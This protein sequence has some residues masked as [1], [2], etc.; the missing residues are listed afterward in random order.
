MVSERET[1]AAG[2]RVGESPCEQDPTVMTEGKELKNVSES[3]SPHESSEAATIQTSGSMF[4]VKVQMPGSDVLDIQVS[5]K[6]LVQEIIQVLMEH[7]DS[8]HRTCFSLQ[9]EGNVLDN[10][11][12]LRS[13]EGLKDGSLLKV[14][15]EPYTIR[16]ARIH[17]R[18]FRDLLKNLDPTDAY[19]GVDCSSLSF[20]S[21]LS[22]G[23]IADRTCHENN[24]KKKKR[25]FTEQEL[26]SIDCSPPDYILP[27]CAERPLAPLQ[28]L[29][30]DCKPLQC[31]KALMMSG[32][33]PPPGN[34]KMHGDLMYLSV[35][36]MEDHHIHITASNRGF[37]I[38]QST[39][40]IFN[41]KPANP[42]HL[43]HSLVELLG[44]ISPAF[45]K[46]FTALQKK[47]IHRHPL[48]RIATPFQT[49]TW[50]A[51]STNHIMDYVRAEDV[52]TSRLGYEEHIPGHTRDWNEELQ[53]TKELPHDSSTDQLLRERATFKIHSDFVAA[54]TRGAM[55]VVDGNVM[56]INPGEEVKMQMFIWNNIFFSFS[57][58][59]RDHYKELGGDE[60]AH[61]AAGHDLKGVQA[62]SSLDIEDLYV[63]G[64]VVLD[65]RGHR[66]TAQSIIPGILDRKEDQGVMY[67]SIDFG[68]TVSSDA[69]YLALLQKASKPL[70]IQKH[71]VLNEKDEPVVLC[72]SVE[73]KGI[74]GNDGRYYILDLLRT[75]P[76]DLNFLALDKEE[77][78]EECRKLQFPRTYQH[79]LCCLRPELVES[80]VQHK[81]TQFMNLVM[82]RTHD[83]GTFGENN[84]SKDGEREE[85]NII[86]DVCREVGSVSDVVFD[87]RFNPD[88]CSSVVKFP[89]SEKEA[90]Q[91]QRRLLKEASAFLL[92]V[93]I[94]NFIKECLHYGTVPLDGATLT[95]AL[96][97]HGI[98]IRYLGA[99][100]VVLEQ[101]A[102]GHL[103]DHIYRIV[104]G[105]IVT[106]SAKKILRRYLQG[107]EMSALSAAASHFLNCFVSSYP[108]P[109]AHLPPDELVSRRRKGKRRLRSTE[110]A[111]AT[112]WSSLTPLELWK[113]IK[114]ESSHSFHFS[115]ICDGMDQLVEKFKLQKVS[116]LR[117]LCMKTGIQILLREYNFES[118]H[119]PAF[120]EEDVLNMFP[121]V[122]HSHIK[123]KEATRVFQ[124][125]QANIQQGNL[126]DGVVLLNEALTLLNNVYGAMHPD[127]GLCLRLL[128][129]LKF[130]LGDVAAALDI[131]QKT[132]IMTE[133]MLGYEHANTI[134]EYILLA[135]YCFA[136]GQ[137]PVSLKLLY[138]AR[139]LM[140]LIAGEDHPTMAILDSNIGVVLQAVLEWDLALRFLEKAL[141][142][143]TKYHG[144]RSLQVALSHH[145][146]ALVYTSKVEFR[147]AMQHE[148][149]TYTIYKTLLGDSHE[150]TKESTAFLKH[151]TQQA[152]NL[153]RTINEIYK[154]GS[155]ATIP[156]VQIMPPEPATLLEQLN[157]INSIALINARDK[158]PE[159]DTKGKPGPVEHKPNVNRV[160]SG[161]TAPR[162]PLIDREAA[163]ES[164]NAEHNDQGADCSQSST[165]ASTMHCT[166][167]HLS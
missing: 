145:L 138:R 10:F 59:V 150:R 110:S 14:I 76:P 55:A 50:T 57:F 156:Q 125:A 109:V 70:R 131:Q 107:T 148:K 82:D 23:D 56:A 152:V 42:S 11:A 43:C 97:A 51:P 34:R 88:V 87:L 47:R 29:N 4:N 112:V 106:R 151:V 5:P 81:Y 16:E 79:K 7:E 162:Q 46:N 122:K 3:Q 132:V 44:L 90:N 101:S 89:E 58:D 67:G 149:E 27:G 8:C 6:E 92:S 139:Y 20:L 80:F 120:T 114:T 15:E 105:E 102:D 137:L 26:E 32:W 146:V 141:E 74:V 155:S 95:E 129:K 108:N 62:Y 77:V 103:L 72:S 128:G 111:D 33:N 163:G 142:T 30:A 35:F 41:P 159:K 22:E 91:L 158:E 153:Q 53:T 133:R 65:Y 12:E 161:E 93:Q 157:L 124:T 24:G 63:L 39:D 19:N 31:L 61:V 104:V 140:L 119:K 36:T 134:Q 38:N 164:T 96:H 100:A 52:Y 154:N 135:L 86:R 73:C 2:D 126:K 115:F 123:S 83:I 60:A 118:R 98:N 127:V 28:P 45:K 78:P 99:V 166:E 9:H 1:Q 13:V 85:V 117:E 37:Y 69:K 66:V 116:L 143:S 147:S 21:V 167:P 160:Q 165:A 144:A 48:E 68:K 25:S 136:N 113:Q 121:V 49:Y 64:T 75:F 94:P 40:D 130:I 71:S 18:H 17:I 84:L 54:S